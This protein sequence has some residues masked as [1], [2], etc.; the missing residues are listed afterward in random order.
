MCTSPALLYGASPSPGELLQKLLSVTK[1]SGHLSHIM[2]AG[3]SDDV[4]DAAKKAQAEGKGPSVGTTL[5]QPNGEQLQE[6]GAGGV[7]RGC[8]APE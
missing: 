5:V 8:V 3:S 2:N 1:P 7:R 6:V 4:L